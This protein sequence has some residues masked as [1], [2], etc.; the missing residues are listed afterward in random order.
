MC[1][2]KDEMV[3]F[4]EPMSWNE[5]EQFPIQPPDGHLLVEILLCRAGEAS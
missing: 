5:N 3:G 4:M 1:M 2:N